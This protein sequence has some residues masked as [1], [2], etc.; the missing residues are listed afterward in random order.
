[1]RRHGARVSLEVL[2]AAKDL[3]VRRDTRAPAAHESH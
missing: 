1:L 2:R 3:E